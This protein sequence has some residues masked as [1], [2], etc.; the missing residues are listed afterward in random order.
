VDRIEPNGGVTDLYLQT[1]GHDLI[2]RSRR[3]IDPGEGGR[4]FQFEINLAKTQLFDPVS[5]RR[6]MAET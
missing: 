5:G 4:R 1:G 3:W 6:I 2:C